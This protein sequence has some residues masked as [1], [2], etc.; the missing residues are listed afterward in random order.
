MKNKPVSHNPVSSVLI[1]ALWFLPAL[2]YWL[3][4]PQW[5]DSGYISQTNSFLLTLLLVLVYHHS[6]NNPKT[7]SKRVK[8]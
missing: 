8:S 1:P 4:F 3:G 5:T 6:N 2:N 7:D